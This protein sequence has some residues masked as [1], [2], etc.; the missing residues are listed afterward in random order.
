MMTFTL[1]FS[2]VLEIDDECFAKI[3]HQNPHLDFERTARGELVIKPL[4][5][6]LHGNR[7][8]E[9]IAAL[10]Q[11]NNQT[12]LG[13]AFS[14]STGFHLPNHALYSPDTAWIELSKWQN[15]DPKER[16]KFARLCPD[17][18]IELRSESDSL[19][20]LQQKMVEYI[21]NGVKLG[22]LIDP[23]TEQV[24]IYRVDS[25]PEVLLKPDV[26]KGEQVLRDFICELDF[27]W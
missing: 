23:Q 1:D 12:K 3:C 8:A 7:E 17:F 27:L 18:V 15:L 21:D 2:S 26:L 20:T 4:S 9:L 13:K 24:T 19:K 10:W 16:K 5:S 11:W 22:W 25:E 6:A 14:S